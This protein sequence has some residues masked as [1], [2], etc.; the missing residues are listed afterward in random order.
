[1]VKK[2]KDLRKREDRREFVVF[3][4]FIYDRVLSVLIYRKLYN[5]DH[6]HLSTPIFKIVYF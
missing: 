4:F 6:C 5:L 1:M 2:K 3:P